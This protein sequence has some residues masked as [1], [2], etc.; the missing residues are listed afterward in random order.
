MGES[1]ECKNKMIL[2]LG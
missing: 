1:E 2:I